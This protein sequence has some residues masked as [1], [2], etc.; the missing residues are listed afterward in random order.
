[1][2]KICLKRVIDLTIQQYVDKTI[3]QSND[4]YVST[5]EATDY[6][7]SLFLYLG[8]EKS[9]KWPTLQRIY[10]LFIQLNMCA[11]LPLSFTLTCYYEYKKLT[12]EQLLTSLQAFINVLGIPAKVITVIISFKYLHQAL[13]ALDT[14]DARCQNPHEYDKIQH[15]AMM[16]NR[17]TTFYST[18]YCVYVAATITTSLSMGKQAYSLFIPFINWRNSMLEFVVQSFIE[19]IAI[20][21][22]VLYQAAIDVYPV[23]YIYG[24]RTHMK[25]LVER[26]RRL[27]ADGK[28]TQNDHY[29]ELVMCVKDHQDLLRLVN[30]ISP[31]ISITM[32]IQFMITAGILGTTLI[33][34]FIFADFSTQI[35]S[36]LYLI[37]VMVQTTPCCYNA[38]CLFEESDQLSLAIFHCEWFDKDIRFRKLMLFFMMRSQ[39]P[40]TLT[41]MKLF[42]ITLN[43]SL[44]IAKFS[45]SLYTLIKEMDFGKHFED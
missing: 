22:A 31:V 41:A 43:T 28:I 38:S 4:H 23:I 35:A 33:N 11:L 15:C 2:E 8:V 13:K 3:E 44:G 25:I 7:F 16:G 1:M 20:N 40:I 26:V 17:F 14:L 6:L 21:I 19:F 32:F 9:Q 10:S 42:P 36:V 12:T 27:G 45:F 39:M 24:I 30:I 18:L 37:A 34:I 29:E 5:R